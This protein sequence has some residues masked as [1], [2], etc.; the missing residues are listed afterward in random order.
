[1]VKEHI[2]KKP[3]SIVSGDRFATI[4]NFTPTYSVSIKATYHFEN[5]SWI[6]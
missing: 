5:L 6:Y 2:V 1:M 4:G 3:V